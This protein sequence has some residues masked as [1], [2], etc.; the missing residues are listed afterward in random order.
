MLPSVDGAIAELQDEF[1]CRT[2][3]IRNY[4]GIAGTLVDGGQRFSGKRSRAMT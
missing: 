1:S 3:E 2:I 4:S